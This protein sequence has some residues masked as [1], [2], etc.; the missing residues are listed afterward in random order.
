M[1]K[2]RLEEYNSQF[3]N[4]INDDGENAVLNA[5]IAWN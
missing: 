4:N 2:L 5:S 3:A 1:E